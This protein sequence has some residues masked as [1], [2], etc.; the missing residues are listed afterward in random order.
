MF[1]VFGNAFEVYDVIFEVYVE[2]K[3]INR[4]QMQAPK[5]MI[6]ANFI[7]TAQQIQKDSRPIKLKLLR[8]EIIWDGFENKEKILNC[9][10]SICNSAM[11][12]WEKSK[13]GE[14]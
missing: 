7:Q 3:V 6:I 9:F 11:E 10:V 5:E 12:T 8:Q 2:N 14:M 4:Q 1:N 13:R